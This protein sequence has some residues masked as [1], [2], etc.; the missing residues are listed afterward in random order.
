MQWL[1]LKRKSVIIK[2]RIILLGHEKIF[3]V[4]TARLYVSENRFHYRTLGDIRGPKMIS[5]IFPKY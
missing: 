4:L 3:T 2:D 5:V 1:M